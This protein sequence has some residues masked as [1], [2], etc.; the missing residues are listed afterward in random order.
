MSPAWTR[1]DAIGYDGFVSGEEDK[2]SD[3]KASTDRRSEDKSHKHMIADTSSDGHAYT[4]KHASP[5]V[6]SHTAT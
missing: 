5:Q 1:S 2:V 4:N 6:H 3:A